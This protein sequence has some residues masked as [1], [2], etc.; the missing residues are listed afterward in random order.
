MIDLTQI[1]ADVAAHEAEGRDM[2][3]RKALVA[4]IERLR[5]V[6]N[7]VRE[8][9]EEAQLIDNTPDEASA[10]RRELLA[11]LDAAGGM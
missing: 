6:L 5:A 10:V 8:E 7:K 9:V 2:S 4:E 11:A 3:E 1:K